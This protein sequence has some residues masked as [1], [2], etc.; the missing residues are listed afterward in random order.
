MKLSAW[1]LTVGSLVNWPIKVLARAKTFKGVGSIP[2]LQN[3]IEISAKRRFDDSIE[4]ESRSMRRVIAIK[5]DVTT[6]KRSSDLAQLA[7]L[8]GP[9]N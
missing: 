4:N 9:Y 7:E 5:R 1:N 6:G 2:V 3:I 8:G